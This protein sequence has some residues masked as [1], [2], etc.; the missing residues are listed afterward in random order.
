MNKENQPGKS[1]NNNYGFQTSLNTA[2]FTTSFVIYK[3]KPINHVSHYLEDGAWEFLSD[4]EFDDFE[5][6]GKIVA[7]EEII[8]IDPSVIELSDLQ[9]GYSAS[10]INPTDKWSIKKMNNTP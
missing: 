3:K 5:K 8:D 2:V 6:V 1:K 10:K 9:E 4:D 7:L